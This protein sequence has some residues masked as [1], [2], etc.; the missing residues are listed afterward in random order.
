MCDLTR[1]LLFATFLETKVLLFLQHPRR[2]K[3]PVYT[4]CVIHMI[5]P[6]T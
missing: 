3:S 2:V 1:Q 4:Q 6:P 5:V